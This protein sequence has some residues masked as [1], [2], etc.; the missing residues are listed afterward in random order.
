MEINTVQNTENVIEPTNN[1]DN[2]T[3]TVTELVTRYNK[4]NSTK[5]KGEYINSVVK[6]KGYVP[7]AVKMKTIDTI[8]KHTCFDKD[9]NLHMD[10][11]KR[12]IMYTQALIGN[13]T[14]VKIDPTVILD[15][16][17]RLDS[18]GVL[19]ILLEMIPEGEVQ[20]FETLMKMKLDDLVTNCYDIHAYIDKKVKDLYPYLGGA[21]AGFLEKAG[22]FLEQLDE[23]KLEQILKRVMK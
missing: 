21:V 3:I 1:N 4:L 22:Q 16:Y 17:D 7:Y 10:S 14:N 18:S 15:E 13:Y 20:T 11:A 5:A 2:N 9:G 19:E 8:L 6:V 12:Y 23:K